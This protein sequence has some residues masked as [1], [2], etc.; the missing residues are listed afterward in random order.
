MAGGFPWFPRGKR[1]EIR[2]HVPCAFHLGFRRTGMSSPSDRR[3]SPR[4]EVVGKVQG[5]VAS[6]DVA[7][8]VR[9]MSLGGMSIES[10][11]AFELGA[12]TD[13]LL[14]L[15]DG[16]GVELFGRA[17]YTRPL[18]GSNTPRFLTG[19]QFVDQEDAV[20]DGMMSKLT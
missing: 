14:T 6:T 12:V 2:W 1:S 13:F 3:R 20:R 19:I 18:E 5:R 9:E 10:E 7:I 15:G 17:V 8:V 4:V 11:A 16:A